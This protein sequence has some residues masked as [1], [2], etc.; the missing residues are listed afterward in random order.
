MRDGA[1]I[2]AAKDEQV[3]IPAG[4]LHTFWNGSERDGLVVEFVLEPTKRERDERFFRR[5]SMKTWSP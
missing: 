3:V 1:E 5:S 4:A 2:V